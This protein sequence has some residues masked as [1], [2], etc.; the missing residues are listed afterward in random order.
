MGFNLKDVSEW[1]GHSDIQITAN[2]YAHLDVTR[3]QAMA[4]KLGAAFSAHN[5]NVLEKALE[6]R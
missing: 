4:D 6:K 3:K 1:L 2:T 5:G